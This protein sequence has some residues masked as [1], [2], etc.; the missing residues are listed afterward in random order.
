MNS[1]RSAALLRMIPVLLVACVLP[2]VVFGEQ[3]VRSISEGQRGLQ[4]LDWIMIALYASIVIGIGW[5]YSRKQTTTEEYFLCSRSMG[6]IVIGISLTV[7]ILSTISFLSKPGEMIRYGP[8]HL[9]SIVAIPLYVI[10]VGY[11]LIPA[12]TRMKIMSAYEIL[13]K[14]IGLPVRLL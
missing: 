5:Y 7:S 14:C 4:D 10:P 2:D 8:T 12:F 13:E 1:L 3:T 9:W 11:F 6:S